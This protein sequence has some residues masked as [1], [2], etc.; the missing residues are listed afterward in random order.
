MACP[1]QQVRFECRANAPLLYWISP[2]YI[3][4]PP[5]LRIELSGELDSVGTTKRVGNAVGTLLSVSGR[6]VT[7]SELFISV[8]QDIPTA[9]VTCDDTTQSVTSAFEV[10]GMLSVHLYHTSS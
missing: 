5:G 4:Q 8:S 2:E 6:N 1:G 3:G 10:P 7:S 9:S